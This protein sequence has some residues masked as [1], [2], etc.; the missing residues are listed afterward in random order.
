MF[1]DADNDNIS[2]QWIIAFEPV[3]AYYPPAVS[4]FPKTPDLEHLLHYF[5]LLLPLNI[6]KHLQCKL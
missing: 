3:L 1:N 6:L 5:H 2:F 4:F